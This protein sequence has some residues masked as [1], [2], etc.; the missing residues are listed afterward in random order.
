MARVDSLPDG[1]K[2]VLQTG[3]VI[4]REFS[5]DLI[6]KVTGLQ[7]SDLLSHLS[8]L[9]DSEL[10]YERGIFPQSTYIFKH[11]L[12]RE[13]VYDSI[14]D[15]R[16]K[17]L[18]REI[19]D[20]IEQ[21]YK[22][23]LEEHYTVLSKHYDISENYAKGA[24]FSRLA[25]K[26][27][28]KK[29]FF[30]DAI[31]YFEKGVDCL[32]KLPRTEDIQKQIIDARTTLGLYMIQMFHY[33]P[34]MEVVAPIVE[35][36][37][38]S[39]YK[40]RIA[41]IHAIIGSYNLFLK[42]DYAEALYNLGE[43]LKISED[44]NDVVS[45]FF[46]CSWLG[47]AHSFWCEFEK[48]A[49]YFEKGLAINVAANNLWGM[50][51]SKSVLNRN[52]HLAQGK[53]H[54]GFLGTNEALSIAEES[55]DIYSKAIAYSHHGSSCFF[56]GLFMEAERYLLEGIVFANKINFL[57]L[58]NDAHLMLG[59]TYFE[60][61]EYQKAKDHYQKAVCALEAEEALPSLINAIKTSIALIEAM[62]NERDIDLELL[63]DYATENKLKVHDSWIRRNIANIL[64]NIDDQHI[65]ETEEWINKAIEADRGNG[66]M[67]D[68][69]MDY[70]LYAELF[71]RNGDKLKAEEYL[72]KAID[73]FK[74]C[75]SAGWVEK[76]EKELDA[77]L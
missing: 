56:K 25:G 69:G 28:E 11:A 9:K 47:F 60:K 49:Y 59:N 7:E 14:L 58:L 77:L 71:K 18:H 24:E 72:L 57:F 61:G 32:E 17:E 19:A 6:Q 30:G 12:T 2:R 22:D 53:V 54:L 68:L 62:N 33:I 31:A 15:R 35:L 21:I 64:M 41:Q 29:A 40:K 70:T 16:K 42:E 43:A 76:T 44:I 39:G 51:A 27:A 46:A 37:L 23:N 13:V 52:V 66:T 36:T 3:S 26:A 67:W 73:V 48:A 63:F 4:E 75:G 55:G 50:V 8:A 65:S 45:S 10:A 38:S 74:E 1:A 5:Y 20:A 34:A